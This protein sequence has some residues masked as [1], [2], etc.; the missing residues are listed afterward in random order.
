[1]SK[2]G[3]G[4]AKQRGIAEAWAVARASRESSTAGACATCCIAPA[5]TKASGRTGMLAAVGHSSTEPR[6]RDASQQAAAHAHI[7]LVSADAVA[8]VCASC[9]DMDGCGY[10]TAEAGRGAFGNEDLRRVDADCQTQQGRYAPGSYPVQMEIGITGG[11]CLRQMVQRSGGV[12][13]AIARVHGYGQVGSVPECLCVGGC[14]GQCEGRDGTS[15]AGLA[16]A[17]TCATA[18]LEGRPRRMARVGARK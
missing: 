6:R 10:A 9:Q 5:C 2:A 4:Y 3:T 11:A 14:G 12:D 18:K 1:M 16:L 17:V 8:A 15:R 13:R 7:C